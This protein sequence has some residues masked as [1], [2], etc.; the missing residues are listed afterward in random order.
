MRFNVD[1]FFNLSDKRF[2][3]SQTKRTFITIYLRI[4]H[5]CVR[6]KHDADQIRPI[7]LLIDQSTVSVVQHHTV[8]VREAQHTSD[9]IES[10]LLFCV[11]PVEYYRKCS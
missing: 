8:N 6:S 11:K 3:R 9:I 5:R 10:H 2:A 4:G 7:D 1:V